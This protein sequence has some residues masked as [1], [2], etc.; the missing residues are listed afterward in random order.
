MRLNLFYEDTRSVQGLLST[1]AS[2]IVALRKPSCSADVS[3]CKRYCITKVPLRQTKNACHLD[4]LRTGKTPGENE[5]TR[6]RLT[7]R[8]RHKEKVL[9]QLS[10]RRERSRRPMRVDRTEAVF[11]AGRIERMPYPARRRIARASDALGIQAG[12]R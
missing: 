1:R 10:V 6:K 7:L 8:T 3:R 5:L 2:V 12:L 11:R 4:M 9:S